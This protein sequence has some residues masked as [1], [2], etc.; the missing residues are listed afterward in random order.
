VVPP[1]TGRRHVLRIGAELA[2]TVG[3]RRGSTTD[4]AAMFDAVARLVRRRSLIVAVSD[5]IGGGDWERSLLQLTPRH[6]VVAL[7]VIDAADDELP[8]AGLIVVEDAETG[9]QLVIDSGDPLL[10][11]RFRTGAGERD[12]RLDAGMRRAGV[13]LHRVSTADDLAGSLIE[14]VT[15]THRR[16][17]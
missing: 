5:F 8:N 6:E 16:R 14:V 9:E 13:P 17:A 15:R 10:R 4:L 7:R 2:R 3:P 1:G 11:A 12:A